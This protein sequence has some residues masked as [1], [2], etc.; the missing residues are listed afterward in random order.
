MKRAFVGLASTASGIYIYEK[1][2]KTKKNKETKEG[3]RASKHFR[4]RNLHC[5]PAKIMPSVAIMPTAAPALFVA[6]I[7][8]STCMRRPGKR[9]KR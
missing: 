2:K 3:V 8:Y 1:N 5:V 4:P 7:A 6:S 9:G